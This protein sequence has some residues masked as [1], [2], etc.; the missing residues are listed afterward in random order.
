MSESQLERVY[1]TPVGYYDMTEEQQQSFAEQIA[2]ML[3]RENEDES[4]D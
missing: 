2:A 1:L 4:D 3:L